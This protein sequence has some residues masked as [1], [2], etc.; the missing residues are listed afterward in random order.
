M[1]YPKIIYNGV[2]LKFTYPPRQ[3]PNYDKETVRH[4][5]VA[6]SGKV[7]QVFERTDTFLEIAVDSIPDADAAAWSAFL[8]Y[9]S[10]GLTFDYYADASLGFF[11]TYTLETTSVKL[12][13]KQP[14]IWSAGTLK[15]RKVT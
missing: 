5:N 8:D 6:S 14:G 2:T 11:T 4:I 7:E 9:A 10:Q 15:F 3:V 12:Q 13:W 1:A